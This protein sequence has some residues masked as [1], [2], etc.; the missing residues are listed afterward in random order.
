MLVYVRMI[1]R[2][3][4][5]VNREV[6]GLHEA[7]YLL[8]FFAVL[9]S[10]LAL[11]RD[12]ILAGQFGAGE[13]LDVY[14]TSF[15]IPDILFFTIALMVSVFVLVPY[16]TRHSSKEESHELI[17]SVLLA[18]GLTMFFVSVVLYPFVPW[19]LEWRFPTIFYG[20]YGSELVTMSRI[21]LLQPIFLGASNIL[22]SITQTHGRY[23][24][25]AI[26]PLLYNIG[27]IA[28]VI[29]LYPKFGMQG[30]VYGVVLGALAHLLLQVPFARS[31]GFLKL[32]SFK[33]RIFDTLKIVKIS[34]PRTIGMSAGHI[35]FFFL[36]SIASGISAGSVAILQLAHNL[37][38][39]PLNIIGSSY[40]VAAFPALSRLFNEGKIE[41]FVNHIVT[42]LRHII[43][44]SF[45]LISLFIVLRAQIVRTVLGTGAFDWADTRLTAA[46]LALFIL[47]LVLQGV[48]LL[49]VRGYYAAGKTAKPFIVNTSSALFMLGCAYFLTAVIKNSDVFRFFF[50]ALLRVEG[51]SGTSILMLPFAFLISSALN[52]FL[53]FFFFSRDFSPVVAKLSKIT[54]HAFS[55]SV[56]LGA[57]AYYAL[58]L[59]APLLSTETTLGI[60]L[61]GAIA[62]LLAL[63]AWAVLLILLKNKEIAEV[64]AALHA[65]FWKS[66]AV[67][68]ID[69]AQ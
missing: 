18:F 52:V 9:S 14:Y 67:S 66:R 69:P 43:F 5:M 33:L 46:V 22:A 2:I 21:M 35:A 11:F 38:A 40:S 60:F 4:D 32:T 7:A 27:I 6:K 41:E 63:C 13:I 47:S 61:Q 26:A 65:R 62:G 1:R 64:W 31:Q 36:Y 42:A 3:L 50:E 39:A 59:L 57:T 8:G 12:R 20:E 25:Y 19:I 10:V 17:A 23:V 56:V 45:P 58:D 29:V 68:D 30:L 44:W 16:L 37:Q 53:L 15:R 48:S 49:L 51:L 54:F 24:L 55:A 34:L 28:G